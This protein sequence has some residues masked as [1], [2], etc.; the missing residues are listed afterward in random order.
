[1]TGE[2]IARS[3]VA[4]KGTPTPEQQKL[5]DHARKIDEAVKAGSKTD[6]GK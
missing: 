3:V 1:M 6:A 4:P 5:I 2:D